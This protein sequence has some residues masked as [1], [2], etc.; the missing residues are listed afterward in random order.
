MT[1]RTSRSRGSV[2]MSRAAVSPSVPGIRMSISTTSGR[3]SRASRTAAAPSSASPATVMSGADD[4]RARNPART[5][6][7]S[8][9]SSTSITASGAARRAGHEW[10]VAAHPEP[11][12]RPGS[13]GQRPAERAGPLAHPRQAVAGRRRGRRVGA[14]VVVDLDGEPVVGEVQ[15]HDGLVGV[16]VPAAVGQRLLHDP[17]RGQV[18]AGRQR[19]A[20]TVHPH[21]DRQAGGRAVGD[22]IVEPVQPGGR[23]ARWVLVDAAQHPERGAHLLQQFAARPL[24]GRQRRPGLLGVVV[25]QVERDPGLHVDQRDVVAEDVVQVAGEP[26][27]LLTCPPALGLLPHRRVLRQPLPVGPPQLARRG[28][29]GEPGQPRPGPDQQPRPGTAAAGAAAPAPRRRRRRWQ[30][31]ARRCPLITAAAS[32]TSA[33]RKTPGPNG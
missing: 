23:P 33:A 19:P 10:E 15:R 16:C 7:W 20:L 21:H 31:A 30:Y 3:R 8:S 32:A 6:A 27:P 4:S 17:V 25:H 13:R 24:D 12:L 14:P 2:T 11:A 18:D 29:G 22:E 1:T 9:A 28:H 26:Q 5:S